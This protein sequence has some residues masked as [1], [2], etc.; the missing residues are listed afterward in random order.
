MGRPKQL[1]EIDGTPMLS[2]AVRSALAS[3]C[4][5]VV[6]VV[7]ASGDTVESLLTGLD[8]VPVRNPEWEQGIGTSIRAGVAAL[9]G[10]SVEAVVIALSDQPR[11]GGGTYDALVEAHRRTG[12]RVVASEYSGTLGVPALFARALFAELRALP[13]GEGCKRLILSQPE[14][15]LARH[16][17]PEAAVDVDT[18]ADWARLA[19]S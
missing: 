11:I 2:R 7:G 10:S 18:P 15:Q 16:P 17:C 9:D 1:L 5:P 12:R 8:V 3:R 14:G 4:R 19:E 6:V 13:A